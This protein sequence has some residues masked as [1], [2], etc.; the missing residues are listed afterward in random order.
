MSPE[1]APPLLFNL[2]PPRTIEEATRLSRVIARRLRHL[3]PAL[4]RQHMAEFRLWRDLLSD[5]VEELSAFMD[6]IQ[7]DLAQRRDN[8]AACIAYLKRPRR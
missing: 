5:R 3:P 7:R 2:S 6:T 1:N 4:R 8:S